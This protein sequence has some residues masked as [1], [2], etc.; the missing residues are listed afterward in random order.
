MT[1]D[2]YAERA[3]V[4]AVLAAGNLD[5]DLRAT[6]R[7]EDIYDP[8]LRAVAEVMWDLPSFDPLLVRSE[9]LKRGNRGQATDGVWLVALQQEGLP[10]TGPHHARIVKAMSVRRAVIAE[11]LRAIQQ[12]ENPGLTRTRSPRACTSPPAP[13]PSATIPLHHRA[14]ETCTTSSTAPSTTTG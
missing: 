8:H 7:P 6:I 1:V 9:L 10:V 2:A 11:A 14:P 12:A 5:P 4:G 3:V 13:S